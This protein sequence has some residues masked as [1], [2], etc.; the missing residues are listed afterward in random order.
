M[1]SDGYVENAQSYFEKAIS[2]VEQAEGAGSE[3]A[4]ADWMRVAWEYRRLAHIV[5]NEAKFRQGAPH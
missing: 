4:K 2:A 3:S 5:R 1:F